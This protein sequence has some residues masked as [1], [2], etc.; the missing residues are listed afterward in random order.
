MFDW[1]ILS[2]PGVYSYDVECTI[3]TAEYT[4]IYV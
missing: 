3:I 2:F 1:S 4:I